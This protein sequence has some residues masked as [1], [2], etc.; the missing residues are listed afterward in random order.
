MHNY[1]VNREI[2][3]LILFSLL[4]LFESCCQ[5]VKLR[6]QLTIFEIAVLIKKNSGQIQDR[7]K[8]FASVEG[9]NIHRVKITLY[10]ICYVILCKFYRHN[11]NNEND[12]FTKFVFHKKYT[13]LFM[14]KK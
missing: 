4:S 14:F 13:I 1:S 2:F 8:L 7:L 9:R 12:I 11:K 6:R 3:A 5:R 10:T